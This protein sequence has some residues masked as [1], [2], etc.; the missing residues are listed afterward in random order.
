MSHSPAHS[1][2]KERLDREFEQLDKEK[3]TPWA[4]LRTERGIKVMRFD[5]TEING[6][7][8]EF[9][10]TPKE[11]FWNGFIEPFLKD[12]ISRAF[13]YT[14]AFCTEHRLDSVRP[15]NETAKELRFGIERI[16]A[17]MTDIDRRL[18]GKGFPNTVSAYNPVG[19]IRGIDNFLQER[20][21]AE[22][23][24]F[25]ERKRRQ[26]EGSE[27]MEKT[28]K[29]ARTTFAVYTIQDLIGE[30][31]SGL[32]YK[33]VDDGGRPVAIKILDSKKASREKLK[34][35]ENEYRFCA[36]NN[37][38]NILKVLDHGLT[39][40]GDSFFVMPLYEYSLRK[41]IGGIDSI[42]AFDVFN[43]LLDGVEAAHLMG[44]VHRDLKPENILLRNNIQELVVADFGI[45]RFAEEE[46]YTA[47]ETKDDTRLANFHYAAPE[48]RNRGRNVDHRTDIYA[49][50]LI[51]NELFTSELA[52]GTNFKTIN[53]VSPEYAY[54]DEIVHKML[55]Q[56]PARRFSTI[57]EIKK[58]LI[59]R[60]EE[61]V[62][63]QKINRLKDTVI[64][65]SEIDDPL[66]ED[67]IRVVD[68]DWNH[69]R[70]TIR[71]NQNVNSLWVWALNNMGGYQSVYGM[72]PD[73]FQFV[74]NEAGIA[75]EPRDVQ[76]VV[77]FFKQWLPQANRVYAERLAKDKQ[78]ADREEREKLRRRVEHEELRANILRNLK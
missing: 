67:P 74:D 22:I 76:S 50:G 55:E 25:P 14:R 6:G 13:A 17:R 65:T 37:H 2:I 60:N 36:K 57:D 35:F 56:D 4:F 44:V 15:M 62:I 73:M 27:N 21:R 77:A 59:A 19:K 45:A 52:H 10:G 7:G 72:G 24:I 43:K 66:I 28:A 46:L 63:R 69:G 54:L 16:F 64:S 8:V 26:P 75:A 78:A 38:K 39:D 61:H 53:A 41:L 33:A 9:D 18:R 68:V 11:I 3:I 49:L 70:L 42:I 30:G 32:V 51:L 29:E 40:S 12:I 34:R 20:L 5:G 31:G 58:E 1:F 71:L 23:A 47:V 48:Q